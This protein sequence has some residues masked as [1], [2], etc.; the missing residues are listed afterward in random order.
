MSLSVIINAKD[1]PTLLDQLVALGASNISFIFT[2]D[3]FAVEQAQRQSLQLAV[4][5]ALFKAQAILSMLHLCPGNISRIN[6]LNPTLE[7]PTLTFSLFA[8][9]GTMMNINVNIN[10]PGS[11][12][13]EG[14]GSNM[15]NNANINANIATSFTSQPTVLGAAAPIIEGSNQEVVS[16]VQILVTQL[17]CTL[18]G[19][20]AVTDLTSGLDLS[21]I[22]GISGGTLP[23]VSASASGSPIT[24][25]S[26]SGSGLLNRRGV[27]STM[28]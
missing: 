13:T 14:S 26:F 15:N 21:N 7:L 17:P 22:V 24:S 23:P 16:Y 3:F 6:I 11:G 4:T 27:R 1:L 25:G 20:G 9:M 28:W 18:A 19:S 5:D 12:N 2:P 10:R 8:N